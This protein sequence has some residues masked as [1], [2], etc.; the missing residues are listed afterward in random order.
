MKDSLSIFGVPAAM[1]QSLCNLI[2]NQQ[3]PFS[4]TSDIFSVD[5][6]SELSLFSRSCKWCNAF[7]CKNHLVALPI[8]HYMGS[9]GQQF[10]VYQ[11][12]NSH[13]IFFL[14]KVICA[15][16]NWKNRQIAKMSNR[17]FF[18]FL[19]S[20]KNVELEK[21]LQFDIFFL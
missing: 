20:R 3:F 1:H 11:S 5:L 19:W 4:F 16:G 14:L 12:T 9:V 2:S 15:V 13:P 7:I 8:G 17:H 10:L 21:I 6:V 18:L